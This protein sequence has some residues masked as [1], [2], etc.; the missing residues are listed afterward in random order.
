M[1]ASFVLAQDGLVEVGPEAS[2]RCCSFSAESG[3]ADAEAHFGRE[4]FSGMAVGKGSPYVR[5]LCMLTSNGVYA[6][7]LGPAGAS[8]VEA[9]QVVP[10]TLGRR[11]RRR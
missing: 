5:P 3:L 4:A 1:D 11:L 6:P 9:L 8:A 10:N 7:P 2:S